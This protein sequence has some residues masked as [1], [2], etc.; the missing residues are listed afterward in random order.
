MLYEDGTVEP[1][2]ID[3]TTG[4]FDYTLTGT[5]TDLDVFYIARNRLGRI[6]SR[7]SMS[8]YYARKRYRGFGRTIFDKLPYQLPPSPDEEQALCEEA[9][10]VKE[11]TTDKS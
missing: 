7:C 1:D 6:S 10:K 8:A 5:N 9:E 4:P 2:S 11:D 3:Y